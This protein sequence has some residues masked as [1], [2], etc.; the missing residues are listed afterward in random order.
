MTV[1]VRLTVECQPGGQRAGGGRR[2]PGSRQPAGPREERG[3]RAGLAAYSAQKFTLC[4]V[5]QA[6]RTALTV[7]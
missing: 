4:D 1:G 6:S 2:G 3:P 7:K 5:T